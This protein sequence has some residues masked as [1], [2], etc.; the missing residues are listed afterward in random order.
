MFTMPRKA[1]KRG[2]KGSH[3]SD[4]EKRKRGISNQQV[5]VMCAMDRMGN[6]VAE[7]IC[8]G[9]INIQTWKGSLRIELIKN[10]FFVLTHI[11]VTFNSP[12]TRVLNFN[13]LSEASTKKVYITF[14]I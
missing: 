13:K 2:A 7:P 5:C 12:K 11:K 6:I 9:R 10:L 3:S 4:D 1:H 14:N 8:K